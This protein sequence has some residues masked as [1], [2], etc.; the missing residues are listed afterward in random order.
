MIIDGK[1]VS[2]GDEQP[3]EFYVYPNNG[4]N[5]RRYH[6]IGRLVDDYIYDLMERDLQLRRIPIPVCVFE[7]LRSFECV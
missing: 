5:Q 7:E 1:L 4:D 3:F 6:T 2:I